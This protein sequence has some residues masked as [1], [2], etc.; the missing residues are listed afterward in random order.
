MQAFSVVGDSEQH[1]DRAAVADGRVLCPL[2][3]WPIDPI[4]G[5]C[6]AAQRCLYEPL[7]VEVVGDQIRMSLP[8]L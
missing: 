2:R 5:R 8:R 7:S 3:G 4:D 6:G 1:V